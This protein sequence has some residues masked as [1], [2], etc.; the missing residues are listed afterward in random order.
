LGES[1]DGNLNVIAIPEG[2]AD[3]LNSLF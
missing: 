2:W 1:L 3:R